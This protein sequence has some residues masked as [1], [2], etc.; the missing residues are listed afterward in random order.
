M[1]TCICFLFKV[2]ILNFNLLL[3][4]RSDLLILSDFGQP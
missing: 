4:K 3:Y 2:T 1:K